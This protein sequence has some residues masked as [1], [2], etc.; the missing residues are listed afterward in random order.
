M[1]QPEPNGNY[2]LKEQEQLSKEVI[3]FE[4]I[5]AGDLLSVSYEADKQTH[6]LAQW[7]RS[8]VSYVAVSALDKVWLNEDGHTIVHRSWDKLRIVRLDSESNL[9]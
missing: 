1:L 9:P 8:I 3:G 7:S 4:D 2:R 5:K 6:K